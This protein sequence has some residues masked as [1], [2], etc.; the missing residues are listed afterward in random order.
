MLISHFM[1]R[2]T[3]VVVTAVF[4]LLAGSAL[5][6]GVAC[7]VD[8]SSAYF[9]GQTQIDPATGKLLKLYKCARGH[10]FWVVN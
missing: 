10:L 3:R 8:N 5:A 7:A 9:T 2:R 6:F 4:L 1:S